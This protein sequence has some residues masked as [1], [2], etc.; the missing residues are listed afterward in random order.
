MIARYKAF[1]IEAVTWLSSG[2]KLLSPICCSA[3][4][5]WNP[6]KYSIHLKNRF[7]TDSY[8][9]AKRSEMLYSTLIIRTRVI[10]SSA[11]C[12][13]IQNRWIWSQ[14]YAAEYLKSRSRD[15]IWYRLWN[16]FDAENWYIL[17]IISYRGF[18]AVHRNSRVPANCLCPS[19]V[20]LA[21]IWEVGIYRADSL[22]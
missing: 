7:G 21:L 3:V 9:A 15:P 18:S 10:K 22:A 13:H 14:N 11:V 12:A 17:D 16:R 20:G 5:N 1:K 4:E 2:N 8:K 19:E 6:V